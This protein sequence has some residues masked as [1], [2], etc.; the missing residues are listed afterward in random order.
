M[1]DFDG[2]GLADLAAGAPLSQ[3]RSGRVYVFRGA[4]SG[5]LPLWQTL[6]QAGLGADENGDHFGFSLA[7]GDFD[8]EPGDDLAVGVPYESPGSLGRSGW[9]YLFRGGPLELLPWQGLGQGGLGA[10]QEGDE[11]GRALG[12]GDLDGDGIADLVVGA[13][14]EDLG[15]DEV[16]RA[17]AAFLYRGNPSRMVAWKGLNLQTQSPDAE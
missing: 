6:S 3:A 4:P 8:G 15:N 11:F 14:G 10:N 16:K 13:P 17:G 7:A 9:T 2:D 12:A 1:G 5:P